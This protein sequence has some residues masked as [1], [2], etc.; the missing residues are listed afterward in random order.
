MSAFIAQMCDGVITGVQS[1]LSK[2]ETAGL[3]RPRQSRIVGWQ[4]PFSETLINHQVPY[5]QPNRMQQYVDQQR[6]RSSSANQPSP[7][8]SG[9]MSHPRGHE[10]TQTTASSDMKQQSPY[11]QI[12]YY[13]PGMLGGGMN[14][15]MQQGHQSMPASAGHATQP[16]MQGMQPNMQSVQQRMAPGVHGMLPQNTTSPSHSTGSLPQTSGAPGHAIEAQHPNS[17]AS[18]GLHTISLGQSPP[19]DAPVYNSAP[20]AFGN[21]PPASLQTGPD[22]PGSSRPSRH[23]LAA[24][25][26]SPLQ[27]SQPASGNNTTNHHAPTRHKLFSMQSPFSNSAPLSEPDTSHNSSSLHIASRQRSSSL[28]LPRS[29]LGPGHKAE[30]LQAKETDPQP[31]ARD[32][33]SGQAQA[34]PNGV[35]QPLSPSRSNESPGAKSPPNYPATHA[36][37]HMDRMASL[38]LPTPDSFTD[39]LGMRLE[40]P[41]LSDLDSHAQSRADSVGWHQEPPPDGARTSRRHSA[42][43]SQGMYISSPNSLSNSHGSTQMLPAAVGM[44]S[45]SPTAHVHDRHAPGYPIGAHVG[46]PPSSLTSPLM[47]SHGSCATNLSSPDQQ[48][49]PSHAAH[50]SGHSG[51]HMYGPSS[52]TG[53]SPAALGT[54]G[55]QRSAPLEGHHPGGSRSPTAGTP[56]LAQTL[57]N[58]IPTPHNHL[59]RGR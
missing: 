15:N 1:Y 45:G 40:S 26:A 36:Q 17:A 32:G 3:L 19:L 47:H 23:Q 41:H 18:P 20:A 9:G 55:R 43:N 49:F 30:V 12:P 29:N 11:Q 46:T 13:G 50:G 21:S 6:A 10:H 33:A 56:V 28:D 35:H 51:G 5:Q 14:Q 7:Y 4:Q 8:S 52:S 53:L 42:F 57:P 16:S 59:H 37:S 44:H 22:V 38:A 31:R 54:L 25:D 2:A 39:G 48:G 24:A 27:T 58:G 34:Y